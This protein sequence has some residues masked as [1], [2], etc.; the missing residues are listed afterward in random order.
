MKI[1]G[2]VPKSMEISTECQRSVEN[3]VAEQKFLADEEGRE[4]VGSTKNWSV[5]AENR[6]VVAD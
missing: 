6:S 2:E 1:Y 5:A 4:Q 3:L